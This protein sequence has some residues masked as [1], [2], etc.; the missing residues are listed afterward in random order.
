[1]EEYSQAYSEQ[2]LD[3]IG[4]DV[5]KLRETRIWI[6]TRSASIFKPNCDS[7]VKRPSKYDPKF[8]SMKNLYLNSTNGFSLCSKSE[9]VSYLVFTKNGSMI[10][11]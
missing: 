3:E 11:I 8:S 1:M 4:F 6:H 9:R 7:I 5:N 2:F 10:V